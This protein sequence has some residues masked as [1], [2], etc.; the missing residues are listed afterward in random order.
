MR[1]RVGAV[2]V[3]VLTVACLLLAGCWRSG[4]EPENLAR[5]YK[6][7]KTA[8]KVMLENGYSEAEVNEQRCGA[9]F[10]AT[11]AA[12]TGGDDR[13]KALARDYFVRGCLGRAPAPST[14]KP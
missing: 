6:E 10:D 5:A 9:H 7:G 8:R 1:G 11:E 3:A 12:D 2:A 14:T 4:G 13:F